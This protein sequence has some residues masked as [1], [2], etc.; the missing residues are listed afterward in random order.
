HE[1]DPAS[2]IAALQFLSQSKN[3]GAVAEI[4]R[5]VGKVDRLGRGED[6]RLEH[7]EI[8][9]EQ[10]GFVR[11]ATLAGIEGGH[12]S[13]SLRRRRTISGAKARLWRNSTSPRRTSSRDAEK[14]EARTVARSSGRARYRARWG[15][16][17]THSKLSPMSR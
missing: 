8:A 16:M 2:R 11:K 5:E 17:A 9:L 10:L 3:I 7:A 6:Q 12:D 15:S 4:G 14:L 13:P 1:I